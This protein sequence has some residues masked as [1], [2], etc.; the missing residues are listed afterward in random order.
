MRSST[1]IKFSEADWK[2]DRQVGRKDEGF[3]WSEVLMFGYAEEL[4]DETKIERIVGGDDVARGL[5]IRLAAFGG[6]DVVDEY[7]AGVFARWPV[8]KRWMYL[9][10][11]PDVNWM[12]VNDWEH[13]WTLRCGVELLFWGNKSR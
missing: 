11:A 4:L 1:S 7:R 12:R 5:G 6:F 8:R 10:V 13:E 3:R 9:L 2:S